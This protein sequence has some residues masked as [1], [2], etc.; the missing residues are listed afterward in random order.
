MSDQDGKTLGNTGDTGKKTDEKDTKTNAVTPPSCI[1]STPSTMTPPVN[2]ITSSSSQGQNTFIATVIASLPANLQA[3]PLYVA[4]LIAALNN[5]PQPSTSAAAQIPIKPDPS[6]FK[7]SQPEIVYPQK[8][9]APIIVQNPT[10][11]STSTVQSNSGPI[12]STGQCQAHG[13][14]PGQSNPQQLHAAEK[15]PL[16]HKTAKTYESRMDPTRY[17]ENIEQL[18]IHHDVTYMD[19]IHQIHL[20]FE[21]SKDKEV[22][23]WFDSYRDRIDHQLV[24]KLPGYN[25]WVDMTTEL[26]SLFGKDT[27]LK[28]AEETFRRY[29]YT[30]ES[31]EEY[32]RK[33]RALGRKVEP[34]ANEERIVQMLYQHLPGHMRTILLLSGKY[35]TIQEFKS[36]FSDFIKYFPQLKQ[37]KSSGSSTSTITLS[38]FPPTSPSVRAVG[39]PAPQQQS[40]LNCHFCELGPHRWKECRKFTYAKQRLMEEDKN[41]TVQIIEDAIIRK[42]PSDS[43]AI[44]NFLQNPRAYY[45]P[46]SRNP[47]NPQQRGYN[48]GS[49]GRGGS[50]N[51]GRRQFHRRSNDN[52]NLKE[53][54]DEEDNDDEVDPVPKK[55]HGSNK[56]K[57]N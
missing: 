1:G 56:K 36:I 23:E 9:G 17:I 47:Q 31:A 19:V 37:K 53:E 38:L 34:H 11:T 49:R 16:I 5:Q 50:G 22:K 52:R 15:I 54:D 57:E 41:L 8:P 20:F 48:H 27:A 13:M 12:S 18:M 6:T 40:R 26:Q 24:Q 32:I 3:D 2:T 55:T 51:R 4:Q 43:P 30:N 35:N 28:Q 21:E 25:I 7:V 44:A 29:E 14:A 10:S 39:R 46:N 45:P 33:V 42:I